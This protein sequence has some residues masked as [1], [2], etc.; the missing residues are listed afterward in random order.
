MATGTVLEENS[1][2]VAKLSAGVFSYNLDSSTVDGLATSSFAASAGQCFESTS[3]G[4]DVFIDPVADQ[5]D[6]D[7]LLVLVDCTTP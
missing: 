3:G 4:S 5:A 1:S 6:S 7:E 2:G